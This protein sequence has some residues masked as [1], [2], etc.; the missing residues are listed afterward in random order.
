MNNPAATGDARAA[1]AAISCFKDSDAMVREA[2]VWLLA[3]CSAYD[4]NNAANEIVNL[5]S[6]EDERVRDAANT[7]IDYLC[8]QAG[9]AKARINA[10]N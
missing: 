9:S 10:D 7:A 1:Q 3:R 4:T 2:A 8:T 5:L 6:D